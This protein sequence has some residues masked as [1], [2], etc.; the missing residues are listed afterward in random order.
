MR[1]EKEEGPTTTPSWGRAGPSHLSLLTSP[2]ESQP[3]GHLDD[4][5]VVAGGISK[6]RVEV[7]TQIE[8]P[9][10]D[11]T[12]FRRGRCTLTL[13]AAVL[14]PHEEDRRPRPVLPSQNC[15]ET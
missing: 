9:V 10:L 13:V 5:S 4:E 3:V 11:L 15:V 1:S 14:L 7:A 6:Q 2:L 8:A 12:E